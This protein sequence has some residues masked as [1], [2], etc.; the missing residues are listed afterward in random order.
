MDILNLIL[1]ALS[2]GLDELYPDIPIHSEWVPDKLPPRCFLIG[3]AG[4]VDVKKELGSRTKV[5]GTLDISYL[6]P[7]K[8]DETEVKKELNSV[9]ANLSLQMNIIR[10]QNIVLKLQSHVRHDMDDVMHDLCAFSTFLYRQNETP[11][12]KTIDIDKEELK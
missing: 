7:E 1:A 4:Q 5:S 11:K 3:F 12:I 2:T 8:K 9:F 10:Y 6:P